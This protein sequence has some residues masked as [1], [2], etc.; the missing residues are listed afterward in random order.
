MTD[1]FVYE[2]LS[3]FVQVKIFGQGKRIYPLF[4][5]RKGY[6]KSEG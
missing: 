4:F 6:K 3:I 5:L 1:V 2:S